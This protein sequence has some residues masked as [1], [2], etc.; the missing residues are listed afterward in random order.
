[1]AGRS[2]PLRPIPP[3]ARHRCEHLRKPSVSQ[4]AR[5]STLAPRRKCPG[6]GCRCSDHRAGRRMECIHHVRRVDHIRRDSSIDLCFRRAPGQISAGC[7][8][9][10]RCATRTRLTGQGHRS[11]SG[12]WAA[13]RSRG[14][15][16]AV[17]AA[18]PCDDRGFRPA[19]FSPPVDH[20]R[21]SPQLDPS[22]RT[23]HLR[24]RIGIQR[25]DVARLL[26]FAPPRSL[27]APP[28][29]AC[30]RSAHRALRS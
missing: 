30:V 20:L 8:R 4:L 1:M 26:V 6:L 15:R 12:R 3:A 16:C 10:S 7:S 29:V 25:R 14:F 2:F 18:I 24:D 9:V 21:R 13:R 17:Q 27:G 28:L 19:V 11:G 23:W 5:R 22:L